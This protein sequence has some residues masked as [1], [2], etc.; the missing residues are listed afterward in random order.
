MLKLGDYKF[1]M[2]TQL[3]GL[4]AQVDTDNGGCPYESPSNKSFQCD[5][6]VLEDGT[7]VNL[8]LAQANI[9]NDN[10]HPGP[11]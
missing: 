4:M 9:L 11:R 2:S 8:T 3:A 6:M 10:G 7:E 5:A 1:H